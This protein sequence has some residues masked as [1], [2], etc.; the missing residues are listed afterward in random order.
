IVK[1]LPDGSN[2]VQVSHGPG[3]DLY[4]AYSPDGHQIAFESPRAGGGDI[5]VMNADGSGVVRLTTTL[6]EDSQPAWSPHGNRIAFTRCSSIACPLWT[7]THTC[8]EHAATMI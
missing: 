1:A 3:K 6:R 4:P 5:Y 2:G 7:L 8:W